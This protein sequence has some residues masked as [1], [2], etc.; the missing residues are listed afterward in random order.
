MLRKGF[1]LLGCCLGLSIPVSYAGDSADDLV[2]MVDWWDNYGQY[3]SE[4]DN[5]ASSVDTMM[6][7]LLEGEKLSMRDDIP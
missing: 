5:P 4:L 7:S 6:F 1:L 3:W 2:A